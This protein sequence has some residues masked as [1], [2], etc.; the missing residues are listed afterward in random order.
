MAMS[1]L[2][3][4]WLVI[5]LLVAALAVVG[6]TTADETDAQVQGKVD[7]EL[8]RL[9]PTATPVPTATPTVAELVARFRISIAQIITPDGTGTG[10]VY[11]ASGL[12]ATNAHVVENY[13]QVT[14]VLNGAEYQGTVLNKNEDADL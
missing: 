14:V 8:T 13:R 1:V 2:W 12:V 11:D 4:M 9:A 5:T 6:C 7:A 10:F 3:K